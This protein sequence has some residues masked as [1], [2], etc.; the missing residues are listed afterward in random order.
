MQILKLEMYTNFSK[1]CPKEV[2]KICKPTQEFGQ[3]EVKFN[4]NAKF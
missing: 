4:I 1:M 2:Y 3:F